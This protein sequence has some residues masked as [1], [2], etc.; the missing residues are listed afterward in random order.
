MRRHI[1]AFGVAGI[2]ADAVTR[3]RPEY[4]QFARRREKVFRI[5]GIDPGLDGMALD[6]RFA[7]EDV[8]EFFASG[9]TNLRPHQI[10]A[11]D[12]FGHAVFNLQPGIHFEEAE[13]AIGAEQ[14]LDRADVVV[15][16]AAHDAGDLIGNSHRFVARNQRTGGFLNDFLVAALGRAVAL[17]QMHGGA[18]GIAEDLEFDMAR[19]FDQFFEVDLGC[20]KTAVGH[21][22]RTLHGTQQF[23]FIFSRQHSD[24]APAARRL[25]QHRKADFARGGEYGLVVVG[26]HPGTLGHRHAV[27][28]GHITGAGLVAH[29]VDPF[30]RRPDEM[31]AS[32]DYFLRERRI[33]RQKA[34]TG[35]QAVGF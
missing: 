34:V 27:L 16:H 22:A 4:G 7:G 5:F 31:A 11:R 1:A 19:A 15:T 2:D 29:G 21:R 8:G 3:R 6:F 14:H 18:V 28:G 10:D 17:K 25:H 35:M 20:A 9:G 33:F 23:A 30:R 13:G 24:A 12:F 32:V 26:Q